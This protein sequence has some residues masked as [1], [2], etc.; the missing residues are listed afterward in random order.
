MCKVFKKNGPGPKNGA[1]YGAPFN[2]AD[3]TDDDDD[4]TENHS[5]PQAAEA[6]SQT[7]WVQNVEQSLPLGGGLLDFGNGPLPMLEE[8]PSSSVVAPTSIV[9]VDETNDEMD[10]LLACFDD[11]DMLLPDGNGFNQVTFCKVYV[12]CYI[13]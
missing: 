10:S 8:G 2:E 3:W 7:A 12:S 9:A 11:E 1:Q 5:I 6:P 13:P 4:V